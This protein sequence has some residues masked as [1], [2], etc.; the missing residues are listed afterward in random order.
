MAKLPDRK[1]WDSRTGSYMTYPGIAPIFIEVGT[2]YPIDYVDIEVPMRLWHRVIR[3]STF[4]NGRRWIIRPVAPEGYVS[5]CSFLYESEI[6]EKIGRKLIVGMPWNYA[7]FNP[8]RSDHKIKPA[9]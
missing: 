7:K 8:H 2:D 9:A 4:K 6:L 3:A 1:M 5:I